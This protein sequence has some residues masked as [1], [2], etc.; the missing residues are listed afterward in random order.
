MSRRSPK[1]QGGPF[2]LGFAELRLVGRRV[3]AG[4]D[5]SPRLEGRRRTSSFVGP[6]RKNIK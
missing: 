3:P 4:G 6:T 1:L 2:P 5:V